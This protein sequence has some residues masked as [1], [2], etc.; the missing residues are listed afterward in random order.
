[1]SARK[2]KPTKTEVADIGL[3]A[4]Q[5][6]ELNAEFYEGFHTE[7]LIARLGVLCLLHDSPEY[8]ETRLRSGA[9][10]GEV[11]FR[12]DPGEEYQETLKR[13]AELELLALHHHIAEVLLRVFWVHACNEPC[14]WIAL[15]KIRLPGDL[16]DCVT[17][18]LEGTLWQQKE[19]E[20]RRLHARVIWGNQSVKP[21]G[22]FANDELNAS[23]DTA[24]LWIAHAASTLK[25]NSLY[26][27]YKHGLAIVS[28]PGGTLSLTPVDEPDKGI[29]FDQPPG[30]T[31]LGLVNHEKSGWRWEA[32]DEPQD[33]EIKAAETAVFHN[34][35]S[36]I[37]HT[38][39][40][41]R[42]VAKRK[43]ELVLLPEATPT[44]FAL[45]IRKEAGPMVSR[46]GRVLAYEEPLPATARSGTDGR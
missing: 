27:A 32:V 42:G 4:S 29:S 3:N 17:K 11:D 40:V 35:L 12:L 30:F 34:M 38:G 16:H 6:G 41:D 2:A 31:Y 13:S 5:F 45:R 7:L 18:Y 46:L 36:S 10:W 43:S 28:C 24:A 19:L 22:S 15:A 21:D 8:V 20:K 23:T 1:M 14:P 26:N 37:L 33:Y 39:A 44:S 25:A 9:N